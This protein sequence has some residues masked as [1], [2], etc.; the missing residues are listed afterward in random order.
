MILDR[1]NYVDFQLSP[2]LGGQR[3]AQLRML[4]TGFPERENRTTRISLN[5]DFLDAGRLRVTVKDLGFGE[6]F[7]ASSAVVSEEID[8]R[9]TM[10]DG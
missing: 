8:L 3:P 7:P 5:A 4:L 10:G 1:Q 9:R 2:L 6:L